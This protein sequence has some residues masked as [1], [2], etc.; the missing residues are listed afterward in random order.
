MEKKTVGLR[1]NFIIGSNTVR[2]PMLFFYS[3]EKNRRKKSAFLTQTTGNIAEKVTITLF[4]E[5]N[6]N[7]F[8][9]KLVK[10][11]GKRDYDIGPW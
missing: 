10:I 5:K 1:N 8:R 11:A 4:F 9:R 6:A 2:G 7:F 3:A